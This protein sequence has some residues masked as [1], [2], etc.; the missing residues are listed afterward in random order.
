MVDHNTAVLLEEIVGL[1]SDL[2]A[3]RIDLA[4]M[5]ADVAAI[6]QVME[7]LGAAFAPMAAMMGGGS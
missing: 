4:A 2:G 1:R 3:A 5:R 7:S 6:R